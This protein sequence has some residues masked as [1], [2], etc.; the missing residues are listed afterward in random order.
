[1]G[2]VSL[3]IKDRLQNIPLQGFIVNETSIT[4]MSGLSF[5][6]QG[7]GKRGAS[8]SMLVISTLPLCSS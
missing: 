2:L 1:M 5:H 8:P 4:A 3:V 6:R 7:N